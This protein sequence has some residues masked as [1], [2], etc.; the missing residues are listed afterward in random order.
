[1]SNTQM[2]TEDVEQQSNKLASILTVVEPNKRQLK[3][4]F[5][6]ASIKRFRQRTWPSELE[7]A[8]HSNRNNVV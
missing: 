3:F 2:L 5:P 4:D 7:N 1:M 8:I 6:S